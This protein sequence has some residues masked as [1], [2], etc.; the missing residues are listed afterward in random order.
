MLV[1][2]DGANGALFVAAMMSC[3]VL[4][5]AAAKIRLPLGFAD[6][7]FGIAERQ[8]GIFCEAFR[9]FAGQHH[10][11]AIFQ[12]FSREADGIFQTLQAG[13]RAGA[14]RGSIHH[15]GVAFHFAV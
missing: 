5:L 11:R 3:G 15:D 14:Q 12:D 6:E 4:V 9:A 10:V 7:L 13:G 2:S 1:K 8:A